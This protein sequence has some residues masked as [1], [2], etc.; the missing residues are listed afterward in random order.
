MRAVVVYESIYGNTHA[1]AEAIATGLRERHE[2]TL[3]PASDN[4]SRELDL[5]VDLLVVGG[6]THVHGMSSDF[7]RRSVLTEA[8]K[9][10]DAGPVP[11]IE[12]E[13]LRD[14][15]DRLDCSD[16]LAAAAFDTR[17]DKPLLITGSAAKG[18]AKRLRGRGFSLVAEPESFLVEG[19]AGP[20]V[21]GEL[22]RA[23]EWGRALAG[24][25]VP[26]G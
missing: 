2:V 12:G 22:A 1:I 10:G 14:V 19:T 4:L 21:E 26:A 5:G 25:L 24:A 9:Q 17:I 23:T 13:A 8:E 7:S 18:I 3:M 15:I 16:G 11:H 20:L 6:P